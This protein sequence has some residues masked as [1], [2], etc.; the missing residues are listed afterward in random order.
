MRRARTPAA[1]A[2]HSRAAGPMRPPPWVRRLAAVW[3]RS[4]A[5]PERPPAR[6]P[7]ATRHAARGLPEPTAFAGARAPPHR[8][9]P[10][11]PPRRSPAAVPTRLPHRAPERRHV[12]QARQWARRAARANAP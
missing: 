10:D 6:L 1:A 9:A 11:G 8:S 12:M 5:P 4:A 7:R 2:L 3:L